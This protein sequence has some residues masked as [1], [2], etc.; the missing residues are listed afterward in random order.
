MVERGIFFVIIKWKSLK[1]PF[2]NKIKIIRKIIDLCEKLKI[3]L[4]SRMR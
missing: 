2:D 1:I 4:S 3:K